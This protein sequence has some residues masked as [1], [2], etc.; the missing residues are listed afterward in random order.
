MTKKIFAIIGYTDWGKSNTLY[1]LFNRRQFFPLKSPISC[2]TFDTKKFTVINASNEDRLTKEYLKRLKEVLKK[3]I[4]VDTTFVI[5]ISLIFDNGSHD[6]KTVFEYLNSL[7]D[8]DI[9][10]IVLENGWHKN[11]SLKADD[12]AQMENEIDDSIIKYFDTPINQSKTKFKERTDKII[13][14]IGK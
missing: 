5:T 1:E 4:N 6:V 8:F 9:T 7:T 12:I 10:Y 13:E 11:A 14:L 3:H 2:K